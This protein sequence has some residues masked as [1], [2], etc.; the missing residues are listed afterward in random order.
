M[1]VSTRMPPHPLTF[2][3]CVSGGKLLGNSFQIP[4]SEIMREA[5]DPRWVGGGSLVQTLVLCSFLFPGAEG[6]LPRASTAPPKSLRHSPARRGQCGAPQDFPGRAFSCWAQ[7]CSLAALLCDLGKSLN[8]SAWHRSPHCK[9]ARRRSLSGLSRQQLRCA[10]TQMAPC[11]WCR[12]SALPG[13]PWCP[14]ER[15]PRT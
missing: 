11:H 13:V 5:N 9:E 2:N 10:A 3:S 8:C 12:S 7:A 1:G 6:V 4:S 15:A 14:P